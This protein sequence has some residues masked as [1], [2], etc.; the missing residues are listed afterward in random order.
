[1]FIRVLLV[2]AVLSGAGVAHADWKY[3]DDEAEPTGYDVTAKV[4]A[5]PAQIALSHQENG[6]GYV[7]AVEPKRLLLNLTKNGKTTPLAAVAR[8]NG[9]LP[10]N[11][12]AQRRG[13]RWLVTLNGHT[14]LAAENDLFEDGQIGTQ[15][16]VQDA[17]VQP[18]ESIAFD[19]DFMRVASDV[20]MRDAIKN[21]RQG[22]KISDA[23]ITET[24]WTGIQGRWSTTGLTENAEAQVAQSANP[25][26]F[27]AL[28]VGNNMAVAGRPFW[29]DYS[30]AV[31]A[32]PQ[33]ATEIG[34]LADV[35]DVKNYL[36]LF[37]TATGAPQLR[38]VIDG[39][40]KVL[41]AAPGLGGFEDKQ[42]YRLRLSVAGGTLRGFIDDHEV[43]RAQ[44]GLWARGQVGLWAKLAKAGDDKTGEGVAFDDVQV[45]SVNDFY[46]NFNSI[47]PGRWTPVVG[48]WTWR[49]AATP[50][51]K[52]GS[53]AVMG[54]G[55]W[56]NYNVVGDLS[57]PA[58][59]ATGLLLNHH[60]GQGAYMLRIG[61]IHSPVAA[62]KAQ[63]VRLASGKTQVLSEANLPANAKPTQHWE[64]SNERGY[65]CAKLNDERVV[66]AFDSTLATG[67]A[68]IYAQNGGKINSF[69]IEFPSQRPTWAKV[70]ELYEVEQQAQTMGGWSTPQ[71]F[72]ISHGTG[73]DA[74]WEHKGRFWGDD[75]LRFPLPDLSSGKTAQLS[76]GGE[77]KLVFSN[78]KIELVGA[79]KPAS[80]D[81]KDL[82]PGTPIDIQRRGSFLIL[83]S[84]EKTLLATRA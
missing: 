75:E 27:R 40:P 74:V 22:V 26:A 77:S 62:G 53:Y 65:L 72:W 30:V 82:K 45:R 42:W 79:S 3:L 16:G 66:D 18:V 23:A 36:G 51:D 41:A 57:I 76:F 60:A 69:A 15:G 83:R 20:A 67:R 43:M 5:L 50:A 46:D 11:L 6:D 28:Q 64:F 44:T 31:S 17:R 4:T 48:N 33:G 12:V 2:L 34:V 52:R 29:S 32:S 35:Q 24:I 7:L 13:P 68:G 54:E 47:V 21:P 70:P 19:D 58:T 10:L 55:D 78:G 25:F 8:T 56:S 49:G 81:I 61:G 37:W 38:A 59:G 9:P 14:A 84:G 39:K 73:A 63:I 80:I 71:G 1:M